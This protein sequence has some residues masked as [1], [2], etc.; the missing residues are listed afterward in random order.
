VSHEIESRKLELE[1]SRHSHQGRAVVVSS[2]SQ[3][4]IKLTNR[5]T[6]LFS[7]FINVL[8]PHLPLRPG[9]T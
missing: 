4:W 6:P 5:R 1:S 3:K 8:H 9:T 7:R 2:R